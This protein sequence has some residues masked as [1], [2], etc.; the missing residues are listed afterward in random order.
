MFRLHNSAQQ[1][2]ERMQ[3][4][5]PELFEQ[6]RGQAQAAVNEHRGPNPPRDEQDP[7]PG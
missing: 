4:S 1:F 7:N 3:E 5:D 2:G 6:L